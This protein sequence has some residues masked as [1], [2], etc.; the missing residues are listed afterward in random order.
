MD[1]HSLILDVERPTAQYNEM[2]GGLQ[3]QVRL[4]SQ[5]MLV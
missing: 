4:L 5:K 3:Q 2:T 1:S